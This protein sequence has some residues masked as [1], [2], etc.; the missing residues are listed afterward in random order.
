LITIAGFAVAEGKA[1]AF[2]GACAHAVA[3]RARHASAPPHARRPRPSNS[4][5]RIN[6][7]NGCTARADGSIFRPR[8][9]EIRARLSAKPGL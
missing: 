7:L 4:K 2:D 1:G 5:F 3:A 9:G 6:P 8:K